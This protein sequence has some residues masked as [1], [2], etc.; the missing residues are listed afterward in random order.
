MLC[1]T[2]ANESSGQFPAGSVSPGWVQCFLHRRCCAPGHPPA[3]PTAPKR[4][5]HPSR[6]G[7][8]CAQRQACLFLILGHFCFL[9]FKTQRQLAK[10]ILLCD[11]NP[12]QCLN[13]SFHLFKPNFSSHYTSLLQVGNKTKQNQTTAKKPSNRL[14]APLLP[15]STT[16]AFSGTTETHHGCRDRR[17]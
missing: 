2:R 6:V 4:W 7:W 5:G 15:S 3:C 9:V 13:V 17:Q 10:S 14:S 8:G 11:P 16:Q 1:V 12:F